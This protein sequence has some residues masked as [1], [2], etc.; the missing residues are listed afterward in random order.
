MV[1]PTKSAIRQ[2]ILK[3]LSYSG[4]LHGYELYY[5]YLNIFG[6]VHMRSIY[7]N[8]KKGVI[9]KEINLLDVKKEQGNYSWGSEA[10]KV[11][12]TIGPEANVRES[13]RVKEYF[14]KQSEEKSK[15]NNQ[16]S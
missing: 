14:E 13:K 10:E 12:Y 4:K 8:L 16:E 6:K 7:Y 1:R 2:N 9:L 5:H 3:I 15:K 11:Y